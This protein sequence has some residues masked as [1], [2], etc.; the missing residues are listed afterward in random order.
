MKN[1]HTLESV[2]QHIPSSTRRHIAS[3]LYKAQKCAD[4]FANTLCAP[5]SGADDKPQ[6]EAQAY[7]RYLRGDLAFEKHH[8]QSAL[9]RFSDARLIYKA[10]SSSNDGA[11]FQEMINSFVDP[12]LRYAAYKTNVPRA[13][14]LDAIV[15]EQASHDTF[16]RL[17]RTLRLHP[18]WSSRQ[19]F[20]VNSSPVTSSVVVPKTV[21]WRTKK[22]KLEDAAI[23]QALAMVSCAEKDLSSL[24]ASAPQTSPK[25]KAAAYDE[26]LI[27]SQDALDAAKSATDELF[28][29]G[30]SQG[31]SRM[32]S[33][34]ITRTAL[35]YSLVSWRVGRNRVLCGEKDGAVLE[36]LEKSTHRNS[37]MNVKGAAEEQLESKN[38]M[39]RRLKE[40]VVL[41]D[42]SLQSL[43]SVQIMPGVAADHEFQDELRKKASYFQ[44]LRCL[45]IARCHKL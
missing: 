38:H 3:K 28:A 11:F 26:I 37:S 17:E 35:H 13:T 15:K 22:V 39:L 40:R 44:A 23:A 20:S 31:D 4:H 24:F 18:I 1:A 8:W 45:A 14:A 30:A 7:Q 21:Q 27:F 42:A 2:E 25:V 41:Y 16:D 12:S 43:E 36:A 33:L 34:Q 9:Q 19:E 10:L 6:L 29:D 5:Q 32:Q